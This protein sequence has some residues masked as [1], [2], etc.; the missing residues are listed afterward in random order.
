MVIED[1]KNN[2]L[3]KAGI[4]TIQQHLFFE[5][6]EVK[7]VELSRSKLSVLTVS[8]S[9]SK[10]TVLTVYRFYRLPFCRLPF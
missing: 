1:L 3:A 10:L 9:V 8:V 2:L 7:G 4:P 6:K 5:G